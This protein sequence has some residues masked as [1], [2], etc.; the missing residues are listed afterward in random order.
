MELGLVVELPAQDG[1]G[2]DDLLAELLHPCHAL[3][4]ESAANADLVAGARRAPCHQASPGSS[5]SSWR[6]STSS[7]PRACSWVSRCRNPSLDSSGPRSTVIAG[8]STDSKRPRS[9]RRRGSS[10]PL[11]LISYRA[12][13]FML[14]GL[15]VG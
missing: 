13:R 4:V 14:I 7:S 10:R 11:T 2:D 12:I 6:T 3:V 15:G 8:R 9:H 1:L 5:E